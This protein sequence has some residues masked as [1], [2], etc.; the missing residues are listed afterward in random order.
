[1]Q[2]AEI[3]INLILSPERTDL[4]RNVGNTKQVARLRKGIAKPN[5]IKTIIEKAFPEMEVVLM[6][7]E[8]QKIM[9]QSKKIEKE[10]KKLEAAYNAIEYNS[11]TMPGLSWEKGTGFIF[12]GVGPGELENFR[13]ANNLP[14]DMDQGNIEAWIDSQVIN[15]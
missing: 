10:Y 12:E 7:R 9:K 11:D 2:S 6:V 13:K 3:Y 1:M 14:N 8:K 4:R 5:Q 15:K